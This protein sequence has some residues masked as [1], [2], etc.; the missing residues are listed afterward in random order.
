MPD[1]AVQL[2]STRNYWIRGHRDW[3]PELLLETGSRLCLEKADLQAICRRHIGVNVRMG[4]AELSSA[5]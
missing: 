2:A 5:N 4:Q 3:R 1:R